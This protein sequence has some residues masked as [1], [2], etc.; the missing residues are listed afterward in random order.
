RA[1]WADAT[2]REHPGLYVAA[3]ARAPSAAGIPPL[4]NA[5]RASR[6]L[7]RVG[8]TAILLRLPALGDCSRARRVWATSVRTRAAVWL[9]ARAPAA[10][11]LWA[12]A[13]PA[14]THMLL[15]TLMFLAGRVM[16]GRY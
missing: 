12:L 7:L 2:A 3:H 8:S 14:I 10:R 9:R 6:V 5:L 13:W 4:W 1:A 15:L 16:I 11:E